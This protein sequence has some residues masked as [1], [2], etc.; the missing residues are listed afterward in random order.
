MLLAQKHFGCLRAQCTLASIGTVIHISQQAQESES[1]PSKGD[2]PFYLQTARINGTGKQVCI[3]DVGVTL[4]LLMLARCRSS[5]K[6]NINRPHPYVSA[7][8]A[9][10]TRVHTVWWH[11][12]PCC[13]ALLFANISRIGVLWCDGTQDTPMVE[14]GAI[15]L[16]LHVCLHR[17]IDK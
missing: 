10:S 2:P 12:A 9:E 5:H 17:M 1:F 6:S 4:S 14:S 11:R 3:C 13:M 15:V 16:E 8:M 7:N